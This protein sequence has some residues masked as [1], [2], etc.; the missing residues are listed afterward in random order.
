[1]DSI[2]VSLPGGKSVDVRPG[3]RIDEIAASNGFRKVAIAAKLDGRTV[4]L[5]RTVERDCALDFVVPESPEGLE[6]LRH[7]TAHLMAQAV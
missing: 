5:A 2:L 6:V 3:T 7:S 4:D 1:M